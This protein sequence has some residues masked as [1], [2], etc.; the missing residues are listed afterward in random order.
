[1]ISGASSP[2]CSTTPASWIASTNGLLDPSPPGTSPA[3][4]PDDLDDDVVD[5][6][7]HQ[8]RHAVLDRL[9]VQR[10]VLQARPPR[11]LQHVVHQRRDGRDLA[12]LLAHERDPLVR[13]RRAAS[14]S[15]AVSPEKSP[16]P[17]NDTSFEMVC[18]FRVT[19]LGRSSC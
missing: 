9:H 18:C 16:G 15:V 8:R 7:P 14:V 10:A 4:P 6:H 13:P 3:V 19:R 12:V 17:A 1:M 5:A 11:L 2:S